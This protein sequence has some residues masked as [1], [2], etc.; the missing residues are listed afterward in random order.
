MVT[1]YELDVSH[2][3]IFGYAI[4]VSIAPPQRTKIG[5][6][7][8]LDIY[9]NYESSTIV[10]YLKSLTYDIARSKEKFVQRMMTKKF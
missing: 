5:P 1:R 7:I 10:R 3:N 6:Q 9:V 2:L 4:Y 8:R